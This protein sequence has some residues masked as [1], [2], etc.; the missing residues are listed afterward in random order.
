[1]NHLKISIIV[2]IFQSEKYLA[3][4][5]SSLLQQDIDN[6]EI[7]CI[8]DG[9]LDSSED[10][11]FRF[12]KETDKIHYFYQNNQGVSSARNRGIEF[13][14]GEYLMFVDSDDMIRANSLK[15]LY[16]KAKEKQCDILVFG[17][18][19]DVSFRSPEWVRQALYTKNADYKV[20]H[21]DILLKELGAQPSVCN[22]L[23]KRECIQ[24]I[25]FP[26]YI[27]R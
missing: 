11:V 14:R 12:Q 10:I 13:A 3:D 2:P 17:G 16:K 27:H 21:P 22:K 20:F 25:H 18:I 23:I 26:K 4:C 9:S 15:Y 19:T 8:N 24:G 5:L 1:M 6:Y 7:L